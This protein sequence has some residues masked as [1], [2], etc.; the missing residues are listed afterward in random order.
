ME[1]QK[2]KF[3]LQKIKDWDVNPIPRIWLT[4]KARLCGDGF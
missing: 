2:K 3:V 4:P 1:Y